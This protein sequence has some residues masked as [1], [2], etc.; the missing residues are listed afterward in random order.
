MSPALTVSEEQ[1]VT[2]LGIFGDAV[3]QVA[4][5]DAEVRQ[6]VIDAGALHEVEAAG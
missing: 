2:A 4:G 5:H 6:E 1:L 3:A